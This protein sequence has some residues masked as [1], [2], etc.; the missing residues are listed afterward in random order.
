MRKG[1]CAAGAAL[2]VLAFAGA[3]AAEEG[4][5][6]FDSF[7]VERM[8]DDAGWAPDQTWLDRAMRASARIPGCSASVVSGQ[9]LVLTNHHCVIA[10]VQSL[11]SAERDFLAEGFQ[12]RSREQEL[13]CGGMYAQVLT[14]IEDVT[15]RLDAAT[16]SAPPDQFADLRDAEIALIQR[17]CNVGAR[18]CEVVTLYQGGR[19]ALYT[20]RRFDDVRLVF[21]PEHA[22]AAYGGVADNFNYPRFA[23]D[24]AF[25]RVYAGGAPAATPNHLSLRFTPVE[26]GELVLAAGNPGATSRFRTV[27]EM[28]FERD[29]HLPWRVASLQAARER[30]R[31]YAGLG[32]EQSR[33]SASTLQSLENLHMVLA[34]RLAALRDVAQFARAGAREEDLR[35]RVDR[36]AAAR[37]EVAGAWAEIEA[38]QARHRAVFYPYQYLELRAAEGSQLF[39]W[40]RDI[41][42]AAAEADRPAGER[43]PRYAEARRPAL[44]QAVLAERGVVVPLEQIYLEA[45]LAGLAAHLPAA[46]ASRVLAGEAPAALAARLAQSRLGDAAYRRELWEGGAA[47]TAASDDPLIV[48]VRAWDSEAR[49]IRAQYHA[50]VEGPVA[51][52]HERIARARFRAFGVSEYPDATFTPRLTYGRVEGW[53]EPNGRVYP[54]YT[55]LGALYDGAA[56]AAARTLAPSWVDA[57][58]RLDPG[59]IF[60]LTASVDITNG[61]SGSPLLDR[62]SRVVGVLFDGNTHTLGGEYYYD[63]ERNRAISVASTLIQASLVNVYGMDGLAAELEGR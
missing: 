5:W 26:E 44:A 61:N 37:R 39:A 23:A 33:Q 28:A 4:M 27:A 47:A 52:A 29:V 7:P 56:G 50:E 30:V 20:Y 36:N 22:M 57:R 17:D 25:L 13:R 24:F 51:R 12:A 9:G 32:A 63:G 59:V 45:W 58:G 6:T 34:G 35:A 54:P 53:T 2:S 18:R 41:V 49:A 43:L 16:A 19:Y 1:M 31:A 38:A 62:E 15:S 10:C 8:R 11:S 55:R 40:A 14:S 21:A 42:R 3:A 48:F 46:Q 60:N